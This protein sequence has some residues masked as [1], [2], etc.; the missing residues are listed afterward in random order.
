MLLWLA[1]KMLENTALFWLSWHQYHVNFRHGS[2]R[3]LGINLWELGW[4]FWLE[5]AFPTFLDRGDLSFTKF[6]IFLFQR[7][8]RRKIFSLFAE[9]ICP[10]NI[11]RPR[12]Q[13]RCRVLQHTDQIQHDSSVWNNFG[14]QCIISFRVHNLICYARTLDTRDSAI[15]RRGSTM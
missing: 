11:P 7:C 8:N 9:Y 6:C 1:S 3:I 15:V 12:E 5:P 13:G 10:H 14:V 4:C 2:S